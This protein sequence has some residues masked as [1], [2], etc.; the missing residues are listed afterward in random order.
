MSC[1]PKYY[2]KCWCV[3]GSVR[4]YMPLDSPGGHGPH[5]SAEAVTDVS[6][7]AYDK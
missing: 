1:Y 2:P 5:A 4:R 6:L 3:H 7:C